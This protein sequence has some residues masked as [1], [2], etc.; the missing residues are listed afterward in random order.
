MRC[1]QDDC[2]SHFV[3]AHELRQAT[4]W[5]TFDVRQ[6]KIMRRPFA[7]ATTGLVTPFIVTMSVI[8]IY[9]GKIRS[10]DYYASGDLTKFDSITEI[11]TLALGGFALLVC[12]PAVRS[13]AA[14]RER[15]WPT[16]SL[17]ALSAPLYLLTLFVFRFT[18][19]YAAGG[20]K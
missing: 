11:L 3:L 7:L 12:F 15:K 5:L 14:S 16:Y 2:L 8:L 10:M 19:Y 13:I 6:K 18:I 1:S 9:R 4:V 20:I 17:A